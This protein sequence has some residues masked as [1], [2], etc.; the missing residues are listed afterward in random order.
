MSRKQ[1]V[2]ACLIKNNVIYVQWLTKASRRFLQDPFLNILCALYRASGKVPDPVDVA[3][4]F[5]CL[6]VASFVAARATARLA[7]SRANSS[8]DKNVE[9][10]PLFCDKRSAVSSSIEEDGG[11]SVAQSLAWKSARQIFSNYPFIVR[12]VSRCTVLVNLLNVFLCL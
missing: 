6:P 3:K 8:Y 4:L 2:E 10:P 7:R 5:I 11:Q 12:R 9:I 1:V